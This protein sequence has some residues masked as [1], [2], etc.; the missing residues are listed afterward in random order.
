[1]VNRLKIIA[2]SE[3][4]IRKNKKLLSVID[5]P[6]YDYEVTATEGEKGG[7]LIYVSQDLT[8]LT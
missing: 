8:G 3:R 6:G 4:R 2:T 1:M 7:T 5:I